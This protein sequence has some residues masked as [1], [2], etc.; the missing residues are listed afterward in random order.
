ML[1]S[2]KCVKE[3]GLFFCQAVASVLGT[4]KLG[5]EG[6]CLAGA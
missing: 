6:V 2:V 3:G 5:R 4:L 1:R